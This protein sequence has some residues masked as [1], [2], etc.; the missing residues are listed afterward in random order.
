[1]RT[2]PTV[3]VLAAIHST[4]LFAGTEP[5]V[6]IARFAG[7][8]SAAISYTFDDG[9]REQ[10]TLAVPMLD[11][12]GFKGTF[13]VIPGQ[14]PADSDQPDDK[15]PRKIMSWKDL[16]KMADNGHEIGNHSWSHP[17]LTQ[18]PPVQAEEQLTTAFDA[19][20]RHIG[21]PPLTIAF[22]FNASTPEIQAAALKRHV[23]FRAYQHGTNEKAT[24]E[25]LNNWAEQQVRNKTRGVVMIH[26]I[27]TGYAAFSDPEILRAHLKYVK[28][29]DAD[30]WVDTFA[31][32]ARYEMERKE[33]VLSTKLVNTKKLVITL[34]SNLPPTVYDV[35]LTLVV[36]LSGIKSAR[37]QRAGQALP[38]RLT[39]S[40][41]QLDARPDPAPVVL[42]WE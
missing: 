42:T 20:A 37:A 23:A 10:Y 13:Y 24:A 31:N 32:V 29:R 19:I 21:R 16:K 39:G 11:E 12:V 36:N 1:M 2:L 27:A 3:L 8:R 5:T 14:I 6:H 33:A 22:P 38:V 9:I 4:T 18:L 28:S 41:L 30:I 35:P 26:G 34:P 25:S 17:N 15:M 40:S 7:D